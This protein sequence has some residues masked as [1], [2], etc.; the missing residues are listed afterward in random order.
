MNEKLIELLTPENILSYADGVIGVYDAIIDLEKM[1]YNNFVIPSRGAYPF[2]YYTSHVQQHFVTDFLGYHD[3]NDKKKV[4]LLPFTSDWGD[5]QIDITSGQSRKFWA[6]ILDDLISKR[7]T[8]YTK[9]Y[10]LVVSAIGPRFN[11]NT[12]EL[13]PNEQFINNKTDGF[14]FLDTVVSGRAICEI[15]AAFHEFNIRNYFFIL[16]LDGNGDMLR[17]EYRKI[18]LNEEANG[19]ARLIPVKKIFSEDASPLLNTGITSIVFPSLMEQAIQTIQ[20]FKRENFVGA[21]LWFINSVRHI[22]GSDLNAVR[23]VLSDSICWGIRYRLAD[24]REHFE[25]RITEN[26]GQM[27]RNCGIFNLFEQDYTRRLVTKRI[28]TDIKL[29]DE[30]SASSSHV[31]RSA[32]EGKFLQELQ[33][34]YRNF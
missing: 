2:Y 30:I 16:I 6:K 10:K 1:D 24:A 25:H 18:L 19:R 28:Q 27:V 21:G 9:F 8:P 12:Y 23:G 14:A 33:R 31:L 22:H 15:I 29:H 3:Y 26:A 34:Q 4:L 7:E 5:A 20:E 32:L 11:V 17:P 13:V